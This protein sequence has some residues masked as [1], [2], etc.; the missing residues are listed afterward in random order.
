MTLYYYSFCGAFNTIRLGNL[1]TKQFLSFFKLQ[2]QG[3]K[4]EKGLNRFV[5]H[6]NQIA[7]LIFFCRV[8]K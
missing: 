2:K 1:I 7:F 3:K 8:F 5:C 6:K 4:K